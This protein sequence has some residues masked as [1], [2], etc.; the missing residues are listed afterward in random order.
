[1]DPKYQEV[2]ARIV[3]DR[4]NDHRGIWQHTDFH[5]VTASLHALLKQE[6]QDPA[7][8]HYTEIQQELERL[9]MAEGPARDVT[10]IYRAFKFIYHHVP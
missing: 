7:P 3:K 4:S 5:D 6:N 8:P 9:G 10:I 2:L 1:M